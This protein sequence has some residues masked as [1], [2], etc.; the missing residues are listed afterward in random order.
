MENELKFTENKT[1]VRLLV[2][3]MCR[4][5]VLLQNILEQTMKQ[6]KLLEEDV[7]DSDAFEQIMEIKAKDIEE[8]NEID[9]GFNAVFKRVE[10]ALEEDRQAY[11]GEILTMQKTIASLTEYSM[12]IQALEKKNS[13]AFQLYL[14]KEKS[15]IKELKKSS[16]MATSYYKNMTN[17]QSDPSYFIDKMN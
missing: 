4:K 14:S 5:E 15:Q 17:K 8:I 16:Q 11:K 9:K 10:K 6:S 12:Q 13:I 1:Y 7:M 2:D 3:S